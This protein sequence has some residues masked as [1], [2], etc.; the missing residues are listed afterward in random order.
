ME[1][2]M[3]KLSRRAIGLAAIACSM[4]L[5]ACSSF[6]T[7]APDR[8]V[9]RLRMNDGHWILDTDVESGSGPTLKTVLKKG[10]IEITGSSDSGWHLFGTEF[11][12]ANLTACGEQTIPKK[13]NSSP[14][15]STPDNAGKSSSETVSI[16]PT[17]TL[18]KCPGTPPEPGAC[19]PFN[20]R[21]HLFGT[22]KNP[23]N[24]S[25]FSCVVVFLQVPDRDRPRD[26]VLS[27]LVFAQDERMSAIPKPDGAVGTPR[28]QM[29]R[30]PIQ[31]ESM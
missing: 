8:Y 16:D 2:A 23:K 9:D 6:F 18:S 11:S 30:N 12:A 24:D 28:P 15:M 20:D 5:G 31:K 7:Y 17:K 29:I 27:I 14:S 4:F 1:S 26:D 13:I 10:P 19:G 21:F 25:K 3:K 22:V